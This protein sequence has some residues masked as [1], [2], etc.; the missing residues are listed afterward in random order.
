MGTRKL[1][2]NFNVISENLKKIRF[3]KE[4]SQ[5]DL[6]R[7]LELLGISMH[8][9]DIQLIESNKRTVKDFELWG[10]SRVLNVDISYF[11]QD[12]QN[13]F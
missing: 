5:S 3:E 13:Y 7:E 10:F 2:N 6:A 4:L 11:F 8:K 1:N 9:N 12:I